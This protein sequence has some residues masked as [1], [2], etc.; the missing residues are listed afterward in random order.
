MQLDRSG[1]EILGPDECRDLLRHA[2]VGRIVFTHNALPA[3]Q[4]VNYVLYGE[5]IVFRTSRTS[6]LATAAT[7]VIVAFEI[8]EFDVDARTGWSVVVVGPARR[9]SSPGEAAV[10]E[11]IELRAWAPGQRDLFVRVRPE[12]LSG[13]RIPDGL[14]V[15]LGDA[16]LDPGLRYG[17]D[18]AV[19]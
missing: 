11:K 17:G 12:M 6:R 2:E 15:A 7:G 14:D 1:L 18:S 19:G 3:I 13:R 8:D 10:L 4:P 16:A 9:V 5:D